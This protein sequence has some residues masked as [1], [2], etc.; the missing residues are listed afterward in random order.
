MI[1]FSEKLGYLNYEYKIKD[2]KKEGEPVRIYITF[3]GSPFVGVYIQAGMM[4]S[5]IK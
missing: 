5:L 1:I 4:K 2:I 3:E